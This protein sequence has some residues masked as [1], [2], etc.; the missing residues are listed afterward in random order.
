MEQNISI[1][2]AAQQFNILEKSLESW[3]K[4][5]T[6]IQSANLTGGKGFS[7]ENQVGAWFLIHMLAGVPP[8][9]E[10]L[11][12]LKRLA[13]QTEPDGWRL[14]D[15]L[16]TCQMGDTIHRCAISIKS[17][18]QFTARK[19][20]KDFVERCWSQFLETKD[21]PFSLETDRLVNITAELPSATRD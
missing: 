20:P 21:N 11:G 16:L 3:I 9:D 13:F 2:E 19:A 12:S 14:D 18:R 8:L 1:A 4:K 7:F 17:D 5:T 6:A 10:D 15:L